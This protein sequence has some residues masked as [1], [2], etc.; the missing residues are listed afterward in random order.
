[1]DSEPN[2][3]CKTPPTYQNQE[4]SHAI[5]LHDKL[6]RRK[7]DRYIINIALALRK[8]GFKVTILTPEF[9]KAD[10]LSDIKVRG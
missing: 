9:E 10:A 8:L 3:I 2:I 1:M 6:T 5:I 4:D 7:I